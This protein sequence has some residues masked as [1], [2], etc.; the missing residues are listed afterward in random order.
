[1]KR[2]SMFQLDMFRKKGGVSCIQVARILQRYLDDQLDERAASA[3]A[4]HL[5]EC[6]RCG[7]DAESYREVKI[8]LAH[9]SQPPSPERVSRLT[10]FVAHLVSEGDG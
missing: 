1:V 5:D 6:R 3:V 8:A 2:T 7:L 4:D 9:T 10:S